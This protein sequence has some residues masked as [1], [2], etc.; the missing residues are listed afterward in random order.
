MVVSLAGGVYPAL[1]IFKV[2]EYKLLKGDFVETKYKNT[3]T[4]F[5][6]A[7]QF[8]ILI[9]LASCVFVMIRQINFMKN[10]DLG[11]NPKGIVTI[12]DFDEKIGTSYSII[13]ESLLKIPEVKSVGAS[14][15]QFGDNASR[16]HVKIKREGSLKEFPIMEYRIF[17]GF[18]ETLKFEFLYGRPFS[19]SILSDNNGV[20]LNETAVRMFGF[21]NPIDQEVLLPKELHVVGVVK[22]FYFSPLTEEIEPLMFTNYNNNLRNII[23]DI[24]NNETNETIAKIENVM[25]EFEPEYVIEHN[26]LDDIFRNRYKAQEQLGSLFGISSILC[27]I[28]AFFGLFALSSF[29]I[30]KRIKEIGIRKVN[31][32]KIFDILVMLNLDT[33]KWIIGSSILTLPLAYLVMRIWLQNF[34]YKVQLNWWIFGLTGV[35]VIGIVIFTITWRSW[36][37]ASR[38]PVETLRN[39]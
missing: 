11:F 12:S 32:A 24:S 13:K 10:T 34:A 6:V 33:V 7:I 25:K 31:G 35:L 26:F 17:P 8:S 27:L 19:E 16:K 38:N 15:H 39:N 20:V 22:D 30:T 21:S 37:E 1:K 23:I 9:F 18:L 29:M 4:M 3:R 2:S 5:L 36:G 14:Y 28:I